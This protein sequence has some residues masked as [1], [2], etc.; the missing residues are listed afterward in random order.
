MLESITNDISFR[1]SVVKLWCL[2]L[3]QHMLHQIKAPQFYTDLCLKTKLNPL[4]NGKIQGLLKAFECFLSTFQGNFYFQGLFKTVLYIQ[5]LF[6]PVLPFIYYLP[7]S[8]FSQLLLQDYV[9]SMCTCH[10]IGISTWFLISWFLII[11]RYRS[12]LFSKQDIFGFS[13]VN[14]LI[15]RVLRK[16]M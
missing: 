1:K 5:V 11:L 2:Y 3:V 14:A 10:H 15:F 12:T 13:M 9:F 7:F 8:Y 4:A 6:K 16:I